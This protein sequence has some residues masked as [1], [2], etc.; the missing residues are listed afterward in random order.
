[1][2]AAIPLA[3]TSP[4]ARRDAV[5][6]RAV[7]RL[8]SRPGAPS[9]HDG[10][11]TGDFV[12]VFDEDPDLLSGLDRTTTD[13]LR[14]GVVAP[15]LWIDPGSWVPPPCPMGPGNCFGLLVLDGLIMRALCF[16]GRNC[17]ELIGA[18]DVLRPW[19]PEEQS[20]IAAAVSWTALQRSTVAMLDERFVAA[21]RRWPSIMSQLLSRTVQRSRTLAFQLA[22]V[23]V[24]H[25]DTRMRMLLWHLADR[26]GRV[27]TGG[28]HV[29]LALTHETLADLTCMRRPTA[30]TALRRLT[31]NGEL[32][33]RRDGSWL[34]TGDAPQPPA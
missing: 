26:W 28:V 25:A 33:R 30:S 5:A 34:L 32:E 13:L 15:K 9:P 2:G 3:T 8:P 7:S 27:T 31:R 24:R 19:D 20:S 22:I 29:P 11:W 6:G 4:A 14:R 1:M 23:H 17:P 16:E 21:V 18:G 10:G 12:R